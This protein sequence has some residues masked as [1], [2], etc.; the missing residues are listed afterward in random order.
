MMKILNVVGARPNFMKIAPIIE[1]MRS[2]QQLKPLLVHTGQHYDVQMSKAFFDDLRL[3]RPDINL[4]VGS[5]THATQ[6]AAIM[7]RFEPILQ[8][9][10]PDLV[11]V[12]GD[13]NSTLACS[14]TAAKLHIPVAHVEAGLRSFDWSMPEEIN[15]MVTDVLS[16]LL[17]TTCEEAN[18][19]LVREGIAPDKIFFVG[20]VMI[21]TL[22]K[23]LDA[24]R[25]LQVRQRFVLDQQGYALVTLHRPSNVDGVEAIQQILKAF[26][27][28]EQ[29]LPIVFPVHPRTRK[30]FEEFAVGRQLED[31]KRLQLVEPLGYLEFLSLMAEARVVLTDSG[32]IQEE[33]TFLGIPCLTLRENTE[34]WITVTH[35]TNRLVRV[36]AEAI[37]A[38]MRKA[39][40][41]TNGS[42]KVP[43]LWDG[44][45]AQRIVDILAERA[46]AMTRP[47]RSLDSHHGLRPWTRSGFRPT[48]E[49]KGTT[50]SPAH[51]VR[52]PGRAAR[53]AP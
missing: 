34:R 29:D 20:N 45:A 38:E 51:R 48:G 36:D 28:I 49:E 52:K 18:R 16:T 14:V 7:A 22:V 5:G 41:E 47:H 25:R 19:N 8:Q 3:P 31:L 23:H 37:A 32:G 30:R 39:L 35:G 6:T 10:Q 2:H 33:T 43:P 24:A 15:R 9:H 46:S 13:V 26:A 42:P 40:A 21:D 1:A 11:L 53:G 50:G 12:V 27:L 17:F 44:K 4:E